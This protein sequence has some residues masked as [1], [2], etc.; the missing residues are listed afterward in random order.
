MDKLTVLCH[1]R[2][3]ITTGC[4]VSGRQKAGYRISRLCELFFYTARDARVLMRFSTLVECTRFYPY[5][6]SLHSAPVD[7]G[8]SHF[9]VPSFS[10]LFR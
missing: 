6:D 8:Y 1:Q 4:H 2:R 7:I 9:H 5:R 10:E 3:Y